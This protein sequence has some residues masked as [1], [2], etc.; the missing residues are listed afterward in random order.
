MKKTFLFCLIVWSSNFLFAQNK[1]PNTWQIGYHKSIADKPLKYY[2]STVPGAPHIDI[3]VAEKYKQPIWY[4][5]NVKQMDWMEKTF[6]TYKTSFKKPSLKNGE[7]I[8]LHSK[9][10][11]YEF[12]I[13]LNGKKIYEQEGMF[14]YVDLDLTDYLTSENNELTITILP[15][16]MSGSDRPKDELNVSGFFR[17]N[18]R[19]SFKPPMSYGWD[20]HPRLISRGIWDETYFEV[21]NTNYLEEAEL[22]YILNDQYKD[23]ALALELSGKNLKGSTFNWKLLNPAGATV[24][25]QS[26]TF[27]ADNLIVNAELKD[28]ILWW[29]NGLGNPNLYNSVVEFKAADGTVTTKSQ[30]VG[31][32]RVK[33][34]MGEGTWTEP[35]V[36]PKSRSASPMTVEVNGKIIFAKGSNWVPNELF[37]GLQNRANY[38]PYVKWAKEANFN[39]LRSWGGQVVN[40]ESFFDLCDEHGL[41]VWQEF[42]LTGVNYPDTDTLIKITKLE[43][44]AIIKRVRKH[45]CLAMWSGGNELFN[46]W[47]GMTEQSLILRTLNAQ[48]LALDPLTPFIYTSPLEGMGHGHYVFYDPKNG[49]EV[50]DWMAAGKN[51]YTAYPEFGIPSIANVSEL[52]KFIPAGEL[53]PPKPGTSWETHHAFGVWG[54]NRWIELP[55]LNEYFGESKS[56]EELVTYSQLSQSEGYKCIF[57]EARRQK[58]YCSMAINW[59]FQEPWPCAAN[60]SLITWPGVKKPSFDAVKNACRPVL[61]SARFRKFRYD[62]GETF[63]CDMFVLND[64]YEK[65]PAA[66]V[67]VKLVYDNNKEIEFLNWNFPGADENK[68][69]TGPTARVVLPKMSSPFFKI[70][71]EYV[72]KPEYNSEYTFIYKASKGSKVKY[73]NG[74]TE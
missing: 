32:R 73:L 23:A 16:R 33:I 26:G 36:F 24:A 20:W 57:E 52:K 44:T 21:R 66:Q 31:F 2:P 37:P 10:I 22:R 14:R 8:Y 58:P 70:K 62:A 3:M 74:V 39:M 46:E 11:D 45:A 41:L 61:A 9:G 53:F 59:C 4:A 27:S 7:R 18:A 43:S 35:T 71:L 5:D 47:S 34:I 55:F 12:V 40:K 67:K 29:P 19:T 63:E 69:C 51:K 13:S 25:S 38:E 48:C 17:D 68:N 30:K 72:G 42:P 56:L 28:A 64:A 1:I 50:Y 60:N 65:V 15:P 6:F 54:V 49:G